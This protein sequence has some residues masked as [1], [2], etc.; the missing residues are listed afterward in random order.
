[1]IANADVSAPLEV[2]VGAAANLEIGIDVRNP[3]APFIKDTSALTAYALLNAPDIALN[4]DVLGVGIHIRDGKVR[5]HRDVNNN[6]LVDP[7][8]ADHDGIPD[9][10]ATWRVSLVRGDTRGRLALA[11][12]LGNIAGTVKFTAAGG[13]FAELPVF[14]PSPAKSRGAFPLAVR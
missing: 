3:A 7:G 2:Q 9:E 11:S 1:R 8:D 10:A 6:N 12:V 5:L 4:F 13:L 14:A